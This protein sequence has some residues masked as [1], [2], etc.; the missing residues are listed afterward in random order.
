MY[1]KIFIFIVLIF[2]LTS[3]NSF[4]NSSELEKID[5]EKT[6]EL[7]KK[8]DIDFKLA[9]IKSDNLILER[10]VN[11]INNMLINSKTE[12]KKVEL[13]F[14]KNKNKIK[15]EKNQRLIFITE[16]YFKL[17]ELEKEKNIKE[18]EIFYERK[19]LDTIKAEE[20][21]G[22]KNKIDVFNQEN[23]LN[24][25]L[26]IS[27]NYRSDYNQELKEFKFLLGIAE[28]RNIELNNEINY[29]ID[30][31]LR[32]INYNRIINDKEEIKLITKEIEILEDEIEK[33]K[34]KEIAQIKISKLKNNLEIKKL[35]KEKLT[36]DLTNN[37]ERQHY[38]YK[39]AVN[40]LKMRNNNLKAVKENHFLLNQQ[41][42][43]GMIKKIDLLNSELN[44]LKEQANYEKSIYNYH[45]NLLKLKN[46]LGENLGAGFDV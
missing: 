46:L 30:K 23:K 8:N 1:K 32:K 19:L 39:K 45:L 25:S 38:L 21:K 22:Y 14:E 28:E 43:K 27:D 18:K 15:N 20:E 41:Y 11:K 4:V 17:L 40:N 16:K 24:N 42:K 31:S 29:E 37:L 33:A 3:F 9:K 6:F 34:I 26:I 5:L 7:M 44:L 36:K 2:L 35:E 13:N 10:K 12:E